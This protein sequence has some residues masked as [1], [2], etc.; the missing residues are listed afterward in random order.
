MSFCCRR[1]VNLLFLSCHF[2]SNRWWFGA[3]T[4]TT[5]RRG[6]RRRT[7]STSATTPTRGTVATQTIRSR[8]QRESSR[9]A[10][11]TAPRGSYRLH[12]RCHEHITIQIC[13]MHP[14]PYQVLSTLR[15]LPYYNHWRSCIAAKKGF[16]ELIL[17]DFHVSCV[18]G[19]VSE[20]A[21]NFPLL[22]YYLSIRVRIICETNTWNTWLNK[23]KRQRN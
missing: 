14:V 11:T 19:K 1:F 17:I 2:L 6:I 8:D 13:N 23:K 5:T 3:F 20:I 7:K 10:V 21:R 15:T 18:P 9:F 4:P 22:Y 16:N 12:T